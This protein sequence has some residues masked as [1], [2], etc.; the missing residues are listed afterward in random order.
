MAEI[1]LHKLAQSLTKLIALSLL[2]AAHGGMRAPPVH[3]EN[4]FSTILSDNCEFCSCTTLFRATLTQRMH[5][6]AGGGKLL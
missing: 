2:L 3:E 4:L 6:P 5:V 1:Q